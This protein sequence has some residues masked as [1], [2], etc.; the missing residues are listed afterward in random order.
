MQKYLLQVSSNNRRSGRPEQSYADMPKRTEGT[1]LLQTLRELE[2]KNRE[3][4]I[5]AALERVRA[6]AMNMQASSEL[7]DVLSVL[8]EQ[9]DILGICP[10]FSHHTLFDLEANQ[11]SFRTTGR[12]GQRV[13]AEQKVA[14]DA[15]D[16]WKDAVEN[17]KKGG[18]SDVHTHFYPKEILPQVFLLFEEILTA[19][20]AEAKFF[21]EDFPD[22]MYITQ[23]YCKFGYIGFGH[24]RK[25]TEEEQVVVRRM[26]IEFERLYQRFL[27]LQRAETRIKE[28]MAETALERVRARTMAMQK[29]DELTEVAA[30]LFQQVKDLG[31]NT[32]STGFNVWSDDGIFYTDYVTDPAG[33]FIEPYTV[34]TRAYPVF[35][36]MREAKESGQELYVHF[37]EGEALAETYRQ[38]SRF[39][40]KQFRA[41]LDSGFQFPAKQYEHFVFGSKVSLLFI[42]YES[43][44]EAHDIFKRFGKAFEQTYTRFL[45]LKKVEAQ[46]Q[47]AAKNLV[48][49]KAAR[50]KAEDT[51]AMLQATQQQLIQQEKMASLGELTAGVAHEIQNPLNFV[52]NFSEANRELIEE[53]RKAAEVGN[54]NEV[55]SIAGQMKANEEKISHHG[56]RA[57]AIVKDMLQHARS[58][59][60]TKEPTCV[61]QLTAEYLQ[62]SYR[63]QQAKNKPFQAAVITAFDASIGEVNLIPQDIGRALLNLFNNAFYAVQEKKKQMGNEYMP[64]VEVSTKRKADHIVISVKDNGTG[65][66]QKIIDKVFQPFFTTKPTGDGTGLGLSLS[67]HVV[68]K[69]HG[70]K[71]TVISE[72]GKGTEF[73]VELPV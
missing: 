8:F 10:V 9:Y 70:G 19:I 57:D 11:F 33:G 65:I 15:M 73:L 17:W 20:P 63:G 46:A 2:K 34:D 40:D 1:L 14:I 45:D 59:R 61:N 36:A 43:V 29:S 16:T 12:N 7:S 27:D 37:E 58:T 64:S 67:Y 4:Q 31:I 25:I 41:I 6:R 56:R 13:Q 39:G 54:I 23:G 38:L 22:G 32:W 30:L 66:P 60:G 44:T 68:T 42:T 24:N 69:G 5:E 55:V 72:E 18:P 50:K 71:M 48:K 21:P 49:I 52:N 62:L 51:L 35:A 53:L 28:A 3:L 47:Q 26:A